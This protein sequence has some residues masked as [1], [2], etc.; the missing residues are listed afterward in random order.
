MKKQIKFLF[1]IAC[2]VMVTGACSAVDP[3][4][5][6]FSIYGEVKKIKGKDLYRVFADSRDDEAPRVEIWRC[7]KV[8]AELEGIKGTNDEVLFFLDD[9]AEVMP[10]LVVD[11]LKQLIPRENCKKAAVFKL[12]TLFHH[13]M[14][15][16]ALQVVPPTQQP[17]HFVHDIWKQN[18]ITTF[19][20]T[21][22]L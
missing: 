15:F 3:V 21:S 19:K 13:W 17:K 5:S 8:F 14:D 18:A 4:Y 11:D 6:P 12:Q 22:L 9:E 7:G 16:V 10:S 1:A 2:A 20:K